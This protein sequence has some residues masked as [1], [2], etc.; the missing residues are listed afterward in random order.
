MLVFVNPS[1]FGRRCHKNG[2]F[3]ARLSGHLTYEDAQMV[4]QLFA[5]DDGG[6]GLIGQL[7]QGLEGDCVNIWYKSCYFDIVK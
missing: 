3:P 5:R 1:I 6:T 4:F 2:S 7:S